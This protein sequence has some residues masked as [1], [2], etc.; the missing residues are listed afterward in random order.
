[1]CEFDCVRFSNPIEQY[2]NHSK[3]I[4]YLK[5]MFDQFT[6]SIFDFHIWFI[7]FLSAYLTFT[8][9]HAKF[10]EPSRWCV[11]SLHCKLPRITCISPDLALPPPFS[12]ECHPTS[13]FF[14]IAFPSNWIEPYRTQSDLINVRLR[15]IASIFFVRAR[16]CSITVPNRTNH[17]IEFDLVRL[18]TSGLKQRK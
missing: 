7:Y 10:N 11:T 9:T 15:S 1:M 18:V 3:D 16:L 14:V 13:I 8:T 4:S 2:E 6:S 5:S 12:M 17:M